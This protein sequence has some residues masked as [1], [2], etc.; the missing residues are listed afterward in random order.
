MTELP[1]FDFAD[2]TPV[3]TN[4]RFQERLVGATAASEGRMR[5][6]VLE[7]KQL[8]HDHVMAG[9]VGLVPTEQQVKL[10]PFLSNP[11]VLAQQYL[12]CLSVEAGAVEGDVGL[13]VDEAALVRYGLPTGLPTLLEY[14]TP[15]FPAVPHFWP[16]VFHVRTKMR[17]VMYGIMQHI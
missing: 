6:L 10:Y 17:E 14:G 16:A 1:V 12:S 11:L 15:I 2:T 7:V 5:A 3:D 4:N 13:T 9:L 8:I